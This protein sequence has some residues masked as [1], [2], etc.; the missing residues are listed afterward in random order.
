[1]NFGDLLGIKSTFPWETKEEISRADREKIRRG[2]EKLAESIHPVL[3]KTVRGANNLGDTIDNF[4][5]SLTFGL[6]RSLFSSEV[7][8]LE[9]GDHL[10]VQR[11]GYTHHGLY[12]GNGRIIH[13]LLERIKEDSLEVFA[14]GSKIH[15][16]DDTESPIIYSRDTVVSRA[17]KRYGEDNYNLLINNC[18]S[19][20]RWCRNGT[21]DY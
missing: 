1:M 8:K 15:R 16:K 11:V 18:E 9:I 5:D 17:Y 19:F 2:T 20:V 14:D 21:E 7:T 3:G 10:F 13:Y 12:I 4:T 6:L